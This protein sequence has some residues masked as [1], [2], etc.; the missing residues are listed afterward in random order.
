MCQLHRS[1]RP[2]EKNSNDSVTVA[3]AALIKSKTFPR[4]NFVA[5]SP[6]GIFN[7][8]PFSIVHKDHTV[9]IIQPHILSIESNRVTE[10]DKFFIYSTK[11]TTCPNP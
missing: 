4:S 6:F 11:S 8:P 2:N 1:K 5:L 10:L 7:D 3:A 9:A